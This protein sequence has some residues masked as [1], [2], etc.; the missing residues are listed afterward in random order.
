MMQNRDRQWQDLIDR[1][2]LRP[3]S[4]THLRL[5]GSSRLTY[6][7]LI[8]LIAASPGAGSGYSEFNPGW[9]GA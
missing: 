7:Q 5:I 8:V 3:T 4:P 6:S 1:A 9:A 2:A